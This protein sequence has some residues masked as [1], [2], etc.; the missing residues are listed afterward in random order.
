MG[1]LSLEH[2]RAAYRADFVVYGAAVLGLAGA[3][4][5][6]GPPGH[7]AAVVGWTIFGLAV[8]TLMEYALH[9]F[10]LH[11]PQP[12]RRWHSEHHQRPTAL[13]GLPTLAS[14]GLFCVL[15]FAPAWLAGGTWRAGALT[16]GVLLGYLAYA[17]THHATHH[18]PARTAWMKQRKRWHALHHHA[19]DKPQCFGVTVS[20]WDH[21]FGSQPPSH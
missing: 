5:W 15:V 21:V 16:L 3:L 8:W 1:L 7:G 4:T 11:G 13:I 2:G 12:F 10:V 20:F 6:R 9:R 19:K 18:W 17:L 14:V